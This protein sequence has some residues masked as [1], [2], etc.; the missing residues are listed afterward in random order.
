MADVLKTP[1]LEELV[2]RTVSTMDQNMSAKFSGSGEQHIQITAVIALLNVGF[3][4]L[5]SNF[6]QIHSQLPEGYDDDDSEAP[7]MLATFS[8][9]HHCVRGF[10]MGPAVDSYRE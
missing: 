5:A 8:D 4:K 2:C 7:D 6:G 1:W 3:R 10:F 9:S